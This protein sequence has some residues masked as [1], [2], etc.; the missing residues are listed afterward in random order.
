MAGIPGPFRDLNFGDFVGI[1]VAIVVEGEEHFERYLY[2][3]VFS[4]FFCF[5]FVILSYISAY[6]EVFVY[7]GSVYRFHLLVRRFEGDITPV[8]RVFLRLCT[9]R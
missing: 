5:S 4:A 7:L 2:D 6:L 1:R 9:R 8:F 3:T